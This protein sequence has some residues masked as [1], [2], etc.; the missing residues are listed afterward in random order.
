LQIV[1][2]TPLD[3]QIKD[4]NRLLFIVTGISGSTYLGKKIVTTTI[5]KQIIFIYSL[6]LKTMLKILGILLKVI[7]TIILVGFTLTFA[8][9]IFNNCDIALLIAKITCY[10]ALPLLVIAIIIDVIYN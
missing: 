7:L 8:S 3:I 9:L 1:V 10:T 5:C 4:R 2:V 6:I